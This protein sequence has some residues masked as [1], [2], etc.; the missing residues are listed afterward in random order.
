MAGK[1]SRSP[2]VVTGQVAKFISRDEF[3]RRFEANFFD[4]AFGEAR[5][6]ITQLEAIAWD[7]YKEGRKAPLT[8]KAGKGF[9]DPDYQL[10]VEWK[11]TRDRLL[12]V[13]AH[14]KSAKSKSRVLVICGS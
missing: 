4:P 2:I 9:A 7:G 10:S 14:R 3:R 13:E 6:A 8:R 12:N 1:A 11:R 5:D